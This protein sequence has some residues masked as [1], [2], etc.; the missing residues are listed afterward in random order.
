MHIFYY[1]NGYLEKPI[2]IAKKIT[3]PVINI[4]TGFIKT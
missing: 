4:T 2:I 1:N 3:S